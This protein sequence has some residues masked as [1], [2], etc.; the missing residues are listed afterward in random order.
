MAEGRIRQVACKMRGMKREF[1]QRM[2]AHAN[3]KEWW[4]VPPQDPTAYGKRGKFYSASYSEAEF[5]GR[6][7]DK[8]EKVRIERP[9]V[10]DEISVSKVLGV[11]TQNGNMNLEEIAE[12]D[13][14][15]RNAALS[16]GYDAI[17]L[18][19][20]KCFSEFKE[21]GKLPRSL[22]LNILKV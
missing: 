6:P 20:P 4:H 11:P 13:C 2:I 16:K 21:S 8:P 15:W 12:H 9:L 5:F 14:R 17:I 1:Y 10:G 19:S 3:R 22:E 7:N 18:M